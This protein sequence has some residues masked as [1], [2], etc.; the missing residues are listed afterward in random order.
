MAVSNSDSVARSCL[1]SSAVERYG[2]ARFRAPDGLRDTRSPCTA[3]PLA[4]AA[5]PSRGYLG[6]RERGTRAGGLLIDRPG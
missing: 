4:T 5:M 3:T 1:P 6:S 2:S